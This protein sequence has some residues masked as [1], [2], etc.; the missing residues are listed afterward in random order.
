MYVGIIQ[1]RYGFIFRAIKI[2]LLIYRK[3][4]RVK[5]RHYVFLETIFKNKT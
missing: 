3:N 1:W 5:K 4:Q 2:D